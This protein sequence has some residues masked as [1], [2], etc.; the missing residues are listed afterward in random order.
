[1]RRGF[2]LGAVIGAVAAYY[3]S[4]NDA[5]K[6]MRESANQ[7]MN[8]LMRMFSNTNSGQQQSNDNKP[9]QQSKSGLSEVENIVK[10]DPELKKQVD[11]IMKNNNNEYTQ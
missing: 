7:S 9:N 6:N 5:M 3:L 1:M 10:H 4:R 2:F 8:E 11:D